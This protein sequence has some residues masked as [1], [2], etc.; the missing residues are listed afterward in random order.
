ME[1]KS[2]FDEL[3]EMISLLKSSRGLVESAKAHKAA[4]LEVFQ[5]SPDWKDACLIV[6]TEAERLERLEERVKSLALAI[7][8]QSGAL[9]ETVKV[10]NFQVVKIS[11]QATAREWCFNNFRPALVLD[12]KTFEKAVKDGNIPADLAT[13]ER[14]ARAQIAKEL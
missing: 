2:I 5:T 4:V 10:K 11:D 1:E 14:E 9:P 8:E 13:V 12:T 7:H 3:N 6:D